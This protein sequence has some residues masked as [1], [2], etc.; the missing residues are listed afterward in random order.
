MTSKTTEQQLQELLDKQALHELNCAYARGVDR[1]DRALLESLW[2]PDATADAGMFRGSAR[3]YCEVFTTPNEAM[4]RCAHVIT[5][6]WFEVDGDAATGESYVV[7]LTTMVDNGE[8]FE[9]M[10]G[11]RYL[12]RYSRRDGSWKFDS[13]VFVLDFNRTGPCTAQWD[14]GMFALMT[15]RGS[16]DRQDPVYALSTVR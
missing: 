5:N 3:E 16:R 15:T 2:H 8:K 7:G 9:Q 11:G 10:V 6:E 14:E 12:D 1:A 13:R 4:E